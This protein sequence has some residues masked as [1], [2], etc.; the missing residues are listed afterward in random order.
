MKCFIS[1][2]QFN[3]A[4]VANLFSHYRNVHEFCAGSELKCSFESC[5]RVFLSYYRLETHLEQHN[6]AIDNTFVA[7]VVHEQYDI[8]EEVGFSK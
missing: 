7:Y 2:C 4:V 1:E 5:P 3:T 6:H 8:S